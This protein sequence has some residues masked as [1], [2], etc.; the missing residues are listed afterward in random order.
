MEENKTVKSAA[1]HCVSRLLADSGFTSSNEK[2]LTL[3]SN[4]LVDYIIYLSSTL[5]KQCEIAHRSSPTLID[6]TLILKDVKDL[7]SP[8]K[9]LEVLVEPTALPEEFR[10]EICTY[11]DYPTNYYEFL[12]RFPPAHT[13]K[14]TAIKRRVPDDR[15]Q[16]ARLR[17]EQTIEV[18]DN[19]FN[20]LKKTGKVLRRAN[21]LL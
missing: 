5:K 4:T 7:P 2:A 9:T 8:T 13:F 16:K 1:R 14:N 18:V 11:V 21:Y 6:A 15:A 12:P 20:V 19:L 3:L 10:S 17:N